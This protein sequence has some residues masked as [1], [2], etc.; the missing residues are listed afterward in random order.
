MALRKIW[1]LEIWLLITMAVILMLSITRHTEYA[2]HWSLWMAAGLLAFLMCAQPKITGAVIIAIPAAM[3]ALTHGFDL[4][5]YS[6]LLFAGELT[7][8][9]LAWIYDPSR[10]GIRLAWTFSS[11]GVFLIVYLQLVLVARGKNIVPLILLGLLIYA[12][13]WHNRYSDVEAGMFTFFALAFPAASFFYI[14]KQSRLD[15]IYYKAGILFLSIVTAFLVS[16]APWDPGR[17]EVPE[18]LRLFTDPHVKETDLSGDTD[19][20]SG[21]PAGARMSG[22]SPGSELGGSVSESHETVMRLDLVAGTFP[23]SL[24]LRGRASDY[25]T[26]SSWEKRETEPAEG[27]EEAFT[28]LYH[29]ETDLAVRVNYLK[30]EADLFGLFPT[31]E[32]KINGSEEQALDYEIDS[33]GNLQAPEA[34]FAGEYFLSGKVISR[35]D[36]AS[37]E[38]RPELEKDPEELAPFLQVPEDLPERVRELATGITEAA[39]NDKAKI[40]SVENYLQQYPYTRETTPLPA[41][42]DFVDHFLF[43]LE[44]GYCS[45]YASAMVILLRLNDIPARYV[46]GYRVSHHYE[47]HH[48]QMHPEDTDLARA[49]RT[50][51]VRR[52]SAHA[53][54]EAFLQG[55]GWVAY[56]PTARYRMPLVSGPAEDRDPLR[57]E[58]EQ[59]AAVTNERESPFGTAAFFFGAAAFLALLAAVSFSRVY[60]FFSRSDTPAGLYSRV[61]KVQAA[62]SGPPRPG[63]TPEI[64]AE[65]LKNELPGLAGE[66]EQMKNL[67]HAQRYAANK[68]K[69]A[70][71]QLELASLPLRAAAVYRSKMGAMEYARGYCQLFLLSLF[72]G[73]LL[74]KQ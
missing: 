1:H 13:L 40:E 60:F 44:E 27:L 50:I 14:R 2:P 32:L 38:P 47:E 56:E 6:P 18:N 36:L 55:Y 22:Y 48:L 68:G 35:I 74:S 25:Y 54:V 71:M 21:L 57:E 8:E 64:I 58:E 41:G 53:W 17:L 26:G 37:Q 59:A 20:W 19:T 46:E 43:E 66:L 34:D 16:I 15:R 42:Q 31:R 12:Y 5:I 33:F 49:V 65:K 9:L 61:I 28:Y 24:Y 45:Y 73:K 72:P 67:Y 69:A 7:G 63:E 70:T 3:A 62:F 10:A 23:S 52:D 4:A 11:L 30:A 39:G 29:Y 51:E